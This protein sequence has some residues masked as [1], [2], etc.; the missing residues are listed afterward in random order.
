[1]NGL[2]CQE[3]PLSGQGVEWSEVTTSTSGLRA[4]IRGMNASTSSMARTLAVVVPVLA[5][6]V[7]LLVMDIEEIV[8]V[9]AGLEG[10]EEVGGRRAGILDVHAQEPRQPLVH[11]V[12][13][14]GRRP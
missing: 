6:G 2:G 13:G 5:G 8:V 12:I 14:D 9:V 11:R 3:W 7:G 4:S 1:M 10:V